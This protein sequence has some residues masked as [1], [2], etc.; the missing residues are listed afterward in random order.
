VVSCMAADLDPW[1]IMVCGSRTLLTLDVNANM[2]TRILVS[3]TSTHY[4]KFTRVNAEIESDPIRKDALE[5]AELRRLVRQQGLLDRQRGY[6]LRKIPFT[7]GLLAASI[8]VLVLVNS[9]WLQLL[10][11]VFLGFVFAQLG[12]VGHDAGHQQICSSTRGN[13]LISLMTGFVMALV[14]SWWNDKHNIRHHRSPNKVGED[15]DI[16]VSILAFTEADI[17][18]KTGFHKVMVKY[19]AFM[20]F[21]VLLLAAFSFLFAGI[22]YVVTG[23]KLR[24]PVVEPLLV[25]AH[26]AAYFGLLF[27][28]LGPLYAV[29]FIIVHKSVEGVY[30]GS[31]FAPNHKAMPVLDKDTQMG[32]MRQQIITSRNV[33]AHPITDFIYGGLNCQIEH[34]LFPNMP[35]NNLRKAQTIVKDFCRTHS[36]SYHETSVLGSQKEIVGHLHRLSAPLRGKAA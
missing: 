34:H 11:A 24:Y 9:P 3:D 7:L 10:N 6:Y 5:Y 12:L 23:G 33:K 4:K 14:P 1:C 36:I 16:D 21:P 8:T 30:M 35:R 18:N 31:V 28:M 17:A 13:H 15:G 19:Q 32:F 29:L 2:A 22:H 27:T 25:V 20:F 26:L